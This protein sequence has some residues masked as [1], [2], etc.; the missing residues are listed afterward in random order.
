MRI[1]SRRPLRPAC[2]ESVLWKRAGRRPRGSPEL[3]KTPF[4]YAPADAFLCSF[5]STAG[6]I[7]LDSELYITMAGSAMP[8]SLNFG[9][10]VDLAAIC[11]TIS[12]HVLLG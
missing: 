2:S 5:C 10:A 12:E 7:D 9:K 1:A 3:T 4:L 8:F 11:K 6:K